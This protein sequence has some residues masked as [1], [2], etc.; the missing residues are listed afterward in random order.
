MIP[1]V[2][3]EDASVV[4]DS[5]RGDRLRGR[6]LLTEALGAELLAH[7]EVPGKPVVTDEVVEG[8]AEVD[9][10]L[11]DDMAQKAEGEHTT[12]VGRFDAESE[13]RPSH[14]VEMVV[15]TDKL[16]FFDLET[17]NAIRTGE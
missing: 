8:I 15:A 2:Q 11:V 3:L 17:G 1:T 10:A 14:V 12:L 9:D 6:V 7:V 13:V 16:Q 5:A 4:R